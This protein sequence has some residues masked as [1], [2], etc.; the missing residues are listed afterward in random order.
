MEKEK[1]MMK[2]IK[3]NP[4]KFVGLWNKLCPKCRLLSVKLVRRGNKNA[5]KLA[6][7]KYCPTCKELFKE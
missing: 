5:L 6:I 4:M 7:S 3:D 1:A 2:Y